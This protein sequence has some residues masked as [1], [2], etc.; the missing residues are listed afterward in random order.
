MLRRRRRRASSNSSLPCTA[1]CCSYNARQHLPWAPTVSALAFLSSWLPSCFYIIWA[2]LPLGNMFQF[3]S[4]PVLQ[5]LFGFRVLICCS[6][7][8]SDFQ[9]CQMQ[10]HNNSDYQFRCFVP[11]IACGFRKSSSFRTHIS[12]SV[13]SSHC[14]N[15][16]GCL[17]ANPDSNSPRLVSRCSC[18]VK[19]VTASPFPLSNTDAWICA[20][21]GAHGIQARHHRGPSLRALGLDWRGRQRL[22]LARRHLL[23]APGLCH[24]PVRNSTRSTYSVS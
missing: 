1:G 13:S 6:L 18:P 5:P 17:L 23:R 2:P 24:F 3:L 11:C 19:Q 16:N 10:P 15:T 9:S 7:Q 20:S 22:R 12:W 8:S 4:F 21:V 14:C